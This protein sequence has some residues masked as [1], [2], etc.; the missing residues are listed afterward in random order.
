ML[1]FVHSDMFGA[2]PGQRERD[3]SSVRPTPSRNIPAG[4]DFSSAVRECIS[5]RRHSP[6]LRFIVDE[7]EADVSRE[8]PELTLKTTEAPASCVIEYPADTAALKPG[9]TDARPGPISLPVTL[10]LAPSFVSPTR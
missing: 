9:T 1:E 3:Q 8:T 2:R 6:L 5:D 4:L 7:I 10:R